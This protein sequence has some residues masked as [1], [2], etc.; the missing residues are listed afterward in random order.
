MIFG[1]MG[2]ESIGFTNFTIEDAPFNGG[3]FAILG[4]FMAAGFSFQGT[5][6]LV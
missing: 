6:F 4:V 3:F 2:G 5:E 1:I